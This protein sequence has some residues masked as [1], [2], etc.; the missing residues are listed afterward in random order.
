MKI[1]IYCIGRIKESYFV[2]AINEYSKRLSKY[3]SLNIYEYKDYPIPSNS[4]LAIEEEIKEKECDQ[5]LSK[6]SENAYM[7]ALDLNKKEYDSVS[8]SKHLMDMLVKGKGEVNF[9]IGGSLG[10]SDKAKSRANESITFS[11]M[12]FPHQLCRVILLE[13]LYRAFKIE[14]NEPYHK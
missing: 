14:H 6:I 7:C 11:K 2:D 1:N 5:F 4:S 3:V 13:Q 9:L 12:T 8:F 10:L